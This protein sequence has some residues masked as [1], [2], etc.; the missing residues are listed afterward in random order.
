MPRHRRFT[1]GKRPGT[2]CTGG[3]VS[4]MAGLDGCGKCRPSL[5]F[6][7]QTIQ[8]IASCYTDYAIPAPLLTKTFLIKLNTKFPHKMQFFQPW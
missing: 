8:P 1:P 2:H 7:P 6:D 4:P 3:W 5:G